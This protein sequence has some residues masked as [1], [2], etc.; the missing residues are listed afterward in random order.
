MFLPGRMSAFVPVNIPICAGMLM[1]TSVPSQLFWQWANQSY[2]VL[3]NYVNRSGKEI[4][5]GPLMQSYG[6]AVGASLAIAYGAGKLVK[7]NPTA[8]RL[9]PFVPYLAVAIAGSANVAFTRIDEINNGVR[10]FDG[11][12]K[13][14]G[15]SKK[16]GALAVGKTVLTR[17]L[18]LP[19]FP[20]LA[21][22][23]IMA[24]LRK[25]P[26]IRTN[27]T[28]GLVTELTVITGCMSLAL[29]AALALQPQRMTLTAS[30]LEPQ[31]HK[32]VDVSGRPI[33][34][35]YANKGL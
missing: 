12:G 24:A 32:I 35:V 13:D 26:A 7:S 18:F 19:L 9:G 29:P 14:L 28:I 31:F 21:P 30:S 10:V 11:E 25:I 16:A 33:T 23:V 1:T 15:V 20:L 2:N 4:D 3:S 27:K 8:A 6:L 17:S 22:P 34:T 5:M